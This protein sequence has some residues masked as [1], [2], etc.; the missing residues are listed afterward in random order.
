MDGAGRSPRVQDAGLRATYLER[1]IVVG[2]A[3][4]VGAGRRAL[5]LRDRPLVHH[6]PGADDRHPVAELLHLA[7]QMAREHHRHAAAREPADQRAHVAHPGRVEPGGGFVEQEQARRA[8]ERG[9]DPEPLTHA[10]RVAAHL[11][12][13][14][15]C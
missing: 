8:Q 2:G 5:E 11:V 1:A 15:V 10:V 9:G 13:R 3:Q 7:E 6:A 12:R 14:A 4:P